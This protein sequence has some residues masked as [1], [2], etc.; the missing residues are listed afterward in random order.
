MTVILETSPDDPAWGLV[1]CQRTGYET[2]SVYP[3]L[4]RLMKAGW[5][6]DRWEDPA[7]AGRPKRRFYEP[8]YSAWW[9][10]DRMAMPVRVGRSLRSRVLARRRGT[11]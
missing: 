6:T 1:I 11:G 4:D 5:I 2:G 8:A 9:Y 10:R 3:A 7:P